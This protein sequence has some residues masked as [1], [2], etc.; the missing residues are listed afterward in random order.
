[1][2][3]G[4]LTGRRIHICHVSRRD[5]IRLIRAAKEHGMAVTCEASPHHLFLTE[6]DI[7]MI[8]LERAG[9]R[10]P[11]ATAAD[12]QALWDN[13]DV[14]DCFATDHAPHTAAEKTGSEPPPGFPGLETA[15]SLL[16]QA[17]EAGRLTREGLVQRMFHNPQ[18]IFGLPAQ[19]ETWVDLDPDSAWDVRV[20]EMHSRCGWTPFE[21]MRLPARVRRVT[22]RGRLA[23]EDG[24]VL[25]PPGSGRDL[26]PSPGARQVQGGAS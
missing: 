1:L 11:L 20:G 7:R 6:D 8:G 18:T 24:R 23:Y 19:E 3:L 15:L 9:V 16:W 17:V 12:R 14:I 26:A 25:S 4:H 13:L 2:L 10:P 22:L 5:E 21:G